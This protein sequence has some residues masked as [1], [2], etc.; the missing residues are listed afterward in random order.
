MNKQRPPTDTGGLLELVDRLESLLQD[1]D[2]AELEIEAG[3][4]S[5]LLKAPEARAPAGQGAASPAAAPDEAG[6]P[7]EEAP[8]HAVL[9]P[10]TGIF[11][12]SPTPEAAP[13]VEVGGEVHIG[14]VIGL[15]EAMKLFNEIKSD[16]PGKVVRIAAES[17]TLV[18]AKQP[19]IEVEPA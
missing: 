10:L 2:L 13:Y 14:Q 17:G 12:T 8:Q 9:A 19:L 1:S 11:Y 5:L 6:V 18:R 15:I 3:G 16:L 4:T 7:S